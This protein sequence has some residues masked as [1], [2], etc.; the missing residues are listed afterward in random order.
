M[1][2]KIKQAVEDVSNGGSLIS[3][4]KLKQLYTTMLQCRLLTERACRRLNRNGSAARYEACAGQEALAAGCAL[5]LRGRRR[6]APGEVARKLEG[7]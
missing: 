6:D 3:N 4:A 1:A 2:Y 7:M 5:D